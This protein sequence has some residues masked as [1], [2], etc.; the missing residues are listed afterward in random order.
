MSVIMPTYNRSDL[1]ERTILAYLD[2]D[3][4]NGSFEVIVV[5]DG[6]TDGA[7][8]ILER[9][10]RGREEIVRVFHQSNKGPAAARNVGIRVARSEY[11][12]FAGDDVIPVRD[13]LLR[14]LRTHER[15][16]DLNTAVLGHITWSPEMKIT[17]FMKWLEQKGAQFNYG[18]ITD[19]DN[20]SAELFYS[21]NVSLH[22]SFL[23][24]GDLFDERFTAACWEDI[25][26]GTRLSARGMK[27]IYNKDAL[28]YHVHP[29]D[30]RRYA[31]RAER[32]GYFEVIYH[33]KQSKS[34]RVQP[35]LILLVKLVVGTVLRFLPMGALREEGYRLS[36]DWY[37]GLGMRKFLRAHKQ[38]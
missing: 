23:M 3:G 5:D 35:T 26:L 6:S 36:L 18:A 28:G 38:S 34:A 20:V 24:D 4:V 33:A 31:K 14:H 2:Q 17:P 9:L 27:M 22:R 15:V 19:P 12:L 29:T 10:A 1:I 25:D 13:L 21:S 7:A 30:F 16:P 32:A 11:L 8:E 37:S